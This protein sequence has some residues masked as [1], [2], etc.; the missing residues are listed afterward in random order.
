M[1]NFGKKDPN[2]PMPPEA[3]AELKSY[4][5]EL[6]ATPSDTMDFAVSMHGVHTGQLDSEGNSI[7]QS[8]GLM[9]GSPVRMAQAVVELAGQLFACMPALAPNLLMLMMV[10]MKKRQ[11]SGNIPDDPPNLDELTKSNPDLMALLIKNALN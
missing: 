2:A 10:E 9:L 5:D 8:K 7:I 3:A 11:A 4:G 6:S 1:K